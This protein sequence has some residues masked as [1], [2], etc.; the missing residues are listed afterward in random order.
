MPPIPYDNRAYEHDPSTINIQP[1]NEIISNHSPRRMPQTTEVARGRTKLHRLLDE[2][3]DK[4]DSD[5]AYNPDSEIERQR[6]RRQ[7]RR[8]LSISDD[9]INV[10][11]QQI[12]HIPVI[13]QV[14]ERP[15]PSL[16]RLRYNPYEAGDRAHDISRIPPVVLKPKYE[17]DDQRNVQY[18]SRSNPP[19]FYDDTNIPDRAATATDAFATPKRFGQTRLETDREA[20]MRHDGGQIERRQHKFTDDAVYIDTVSRNRNGYRAQARPAWADPNIDHEPS[21]R[22]DYVSARQSVANTRNI[23]SSI[24]NELQHITSPSEDYHA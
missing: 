17:N 14:Y 10:P 8:G 12:P 24:N 9:H 1:V 4:A 3:L 20:A 22:N 15:D 11:T 21:G 7:R 5:A 6:R 16:V 2:V 18:S 19:L 13:P 23:I